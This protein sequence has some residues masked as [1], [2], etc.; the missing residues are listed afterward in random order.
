MSSATARSVPCRRSTNGEITAIRNAPPWFLKTHGVRTLISVSKRL[1]TI[2]ENTFSIPSFCTLTRTIVKSIATAPEKKPEG[3][4]WPVIASRSTEKRPPLRALTGVRFFAA[5]YVVLF[6]TLPFLK[7]HF[8]LYPAVERF[9]TNGNLAVAFFYLLSGFILAYTYEGKI[10]GLRE[11]LRY[12][13]ARIARIYPVYLLSLL[14]A[15]PFQLKTPLGAKFAVLFM[16]QAWNPINPGLAGAWNYPAW[17]LSV[18]GFFYLCFPLFLASMFKLSTRA[19]RLTVIGL[20]FLIV[21]LHTPTMVLG[22]WNGTVYGLQV[23]LPV[24]R[25]P[26]FLVG[27]A[28]GLLFR[29]SRPRAQHSYLLYLAAAGTVLLLSVPIGSWVSLV[30]VPF[31]FIVYEL[32]SSDGFIAKVFSSRPLVLLGGA[33]Y[34]IY[35]L[36][37]P[38]RAWTRTLFSSA[39]SSLSFA[40]SALTPA[41]LIAFSIAV[42]RYWEEPARKLLHP[43]R[44]PENSKG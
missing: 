34:A 29:R 24:L 35:L 12:L 30:M 1:S 14:L 13:R 28:L 3:Q 21:A 8:R 6:H 38:I 16:V 10:A 42:F 19:L 36:Q 37:Y 4:P 39:G 27:V 18:E 31:A 25:L 2:L 20:L 26:E 33:S 11:Y 32:A 5:F 17:S 15:L 41:V 44:V 7:S 9:L 23:P 22:V 43:A 40:G